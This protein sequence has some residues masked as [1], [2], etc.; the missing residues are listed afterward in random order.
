MEEIKKE[1][2]LTEEQEIEFT[3]GKG[4]EISNDPTDENGEK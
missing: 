3:C 1:I 4:I 2:E